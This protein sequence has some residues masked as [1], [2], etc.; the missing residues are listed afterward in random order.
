MCRAQPVQL[1][2]AEKAT[3]RPE[4]RPAQFEFHPDQFGTADLHVQ[5]GRLEAAEVEPPSEAAPARRRREREL[6]AAPPVVRAHARYVRSS[7][8]KARLVCEHIRGKSVEDARA[9]LEFTPR[10]AGT[11][12]LDLYIHSKV[13]PCSIPLRIEAAASN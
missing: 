10:A 8:R 12:S 3:G 1:A 13:Q 4:G 2:E 11:H 7:A 9:I 6:G 5:A